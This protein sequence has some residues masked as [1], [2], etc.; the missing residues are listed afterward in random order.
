MRKVSQIAAGNPPNPVLQVPVDTALDARTSPSRLVAVGT[1][2][3]T[4]PTPESAGKAAG[5]A[6]PQCR[7]DVP[8]GFGAC[9]L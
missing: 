4:G 7:G 3:G 2:R 1:R 6:V 5:I 9:A 8:D